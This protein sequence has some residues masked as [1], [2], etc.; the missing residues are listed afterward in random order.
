VDT[1][2]GQLSPQERDTIDAIVKARYLIQYFNIKPLDSSKSSF[3][4]K[5]HPIT[6]IS[7][8]I[9]ATFRCL[10]FSL[11]SVMDHGI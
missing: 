8:N 9:P 11:E 3:L 7:E 10:L 5:L 6:Y 1:Q 2:S 4:H